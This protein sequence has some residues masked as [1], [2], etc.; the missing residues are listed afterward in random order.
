MERAAW[1]HLVGNMLSE[2]KRSG[3]DT[4]H[5]PQF[6]SDAYSNKKHACMNTQTVAASRD[7]MAQCWL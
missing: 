2:A 1:L 6:W 7:H 5:I 3:I 4:P